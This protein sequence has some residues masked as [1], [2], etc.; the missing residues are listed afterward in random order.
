[1]L[2]EPQAKVEV[3]IMHLMANQM[4]C[5]GV[6]NLLRLDSYFTPDPVSSRQAS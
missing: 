5:I 3:T 4:L 6:L 1:M 2:G